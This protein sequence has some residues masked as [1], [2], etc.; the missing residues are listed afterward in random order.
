[1]CEVWYELVIT[2]SEK[3]LDLGVQ[4]HKVDFDSDWKDLFLV[5]HAQ[6]TVQEQQIGTLASKCQNSSWLLSG[7]TIAIMTPNVI[8]HNF[9]QSLN[10]QGL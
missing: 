3:N 8:L 10:Q 2:W 1:M 5:L 6:N 9:C 4:T 7:D